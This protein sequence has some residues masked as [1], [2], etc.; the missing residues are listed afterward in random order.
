M[1]EHVEGSGTQFPSCPYYV[2]PATTVLPFA[3]NIKQTL[4]HGLV[5]SACASGSLTVCGPYD[6]YPGY[7]SWFA[8]NATGT[9]TFID[10]H[11]RTSMERIIGLQSTTTITAE[12]SVIG[13]EPSLSGY[14]L[15]PDNAILVDAYGNVSPDNNG[16][17]F[18]LDS[19]PYAGVNATAE[20]PYV[21]FARSTD[22]GLVAE[23]AS[24]R[25]GLFSSAAYSID[26]GN[27]IEIIHSD[28]D[29]SFSFVVGSFSWNQSTIY[30]GLTCPVGVPS[31]SWTPGTTDYA[32]PAGLTQVGFGYRSLIGYAAATYN[33]P[34]GPASSVC[35]AGILTLDLLLPGDGVRALVANATG[36]RVYAASNGYVSTNKLV[37]VLYWAAT[38]NGVVPSYWYYNQ[39][40]PIDDGQANPTYYGG[41]FSGFGL[42]FDGPVA[43]PVSG[44]Y[45]SSEEWATTL[46]WHTDLPSLTGFAIEVER[47]IFE[48]NSPIYQNDSLPTLTVFPLTGPGSFVPSAYCPADTSLLAMVPGAS[49]IYTN[50]LPQQ[51]LSIAYSLVP[52]NFYAGNEWLVCA[53]INL[54]LAATSS[55]GGTVSGP[56]AQF[57]QVVN[58]SGSRTF[59]NLATG[60]GVITSITGVISPLQLSFLHP[61]PDNLLSLTLPF[62]SPSG[63]GLQTSTVPSYST[64]AFGVSGFVLGVQQMNTS[65]SDNNGNSFLQMSNA[66]TELTSPDG[67]SSTSVYATIDSVTPSEQDCNAIV[68]TLQANALTDTATIDVPFSYSILV[69][70]DGSFERWAVCVTG[71]LKVLSTPFYV[72]PANP[73]AYI[74]HSGTGT[75]T[76]YNAW[77]QASTAN[78]VAV[79]SGLYFSDAGGNI[80]ANAGMTF[81]LGSSGAYTDANNYDI[82]NATVFTVATSNQTGVLT[83]TESLGHFTSNNNGRVFSAASILPGSTTT[84]P[85]CPLTAYPASPPNT[86]LYFSLSWTI[87]SVN[88]AICFQGNLTVATVP[89]SP[90]GSGSVDDV[91]GAVNSSLY[92]WYPVLAVSGSRVYTDLSIG[93]SYAQNITSLPTQF[94]VSSS[95]VVND[96]LLGVPIGSTLQSAT[97]AILSKCG[98]ALSFTSPPYYPSG[99]LSNPLTLALAESADGQPSVV[100]RDLQPDSSSF[101]LLSSSNSSAL[102]CPLHTNPNLPIPNGTVFYWKLNGT[103]EDAAA[104][105]MSGSLQIGTE[106]VP[107]GQGSTALPV[108][109]ISGTRYYWDSYTRRVQVAAI[110]GLVTVPGY[111]NALT[112]SSPYLQ[113]DALSLGL[114]FN[115]SIL[116]PFNPNDYPNSQN[117]S[118]FDYTVLT[119]SGTAVSELNQNQQLGANIEFQVSADPATAA[120]CSV[121][122]VQSSPANTSFVHVVYHF[123]EPT[124]TL[125][126]SL[127][128]E[129]DVSTY[130]GPPNNTGS[131]RVVGV[132]GNRTYS[133]AGLPNQLQPVLGLM[134]GTNRIYPFASPY[135]DSNGFNFETT[136][137]KCQPAQSSNIQLYSQPGPYGYWYSENYIFYQYLYFLTP[138]YYCPGCYDL[139]VTPYTP[140]QQLQSQCPTEGILDSDSNGNGESTLPSLGLVGSASYYFAYVLQGAPLSIQSSSPNWYGSWTVIVNGSVTLAAVPTVGPGGNEGYAI[141]NAS[142]TRIFIDGTGAITTQNII[143]VATG[144]NVVATY[145]YDQSSG[146]FIDGNGWLLLLNGSVTTPTG[147]A[148]SNVLYVQQ[149]FSQ[150]IS[151]AAVTVGLTT[152]GIIEAQQQGAYLGSYIDSVLL[153]P[154]TFANNSAAISSAVGGLTATLLSAAAVRQ[155]SAVLPSS[156]VSSSL[157]LSFQ[158]RLSQPSATSTSNASPFWQVCASGTLTV[159]TTRDV[160]IEGSVRYPVTA[161]SGTRSVT[162]YGATYFDII[163]GLVTGSDNTS[164][165]TATSAV[166]T[167]TGVVAVGMQGADNLLAFTPTTTDIFPV[168]VTINGLGLLLSSPAVYAGSSSWSSQVALSLSTNN[169]LGYNLATF[170][171]SEVYGPQAVGELIA[172]TSSTLSCPAAAVN[173]AVSLPLPL[174]Y[175]LVYSLTYNTTASMNTPAFACVVAEMTVSGLAV[176]TP[177]GPAYALLTVNGFHYATYSNGGQD[178]VPL[179][180]SVS[181]SYVQLLY[182]TAQSPAIVDGNGLTL[183]ALDLPGLT[184]SFFYSSATNQYVELGNGGA[185]LSSNV[186]LLPASQLSVV[187]VGQAA[188]SYSPAASVSSSSSAAASAASSSAPGSAVS[189]AAATAST[190]PTAPATSIAAA[191]SSSAVAAV[192]STAASSSAAAAQPV[193]SSTSASSGG[194]GV[195]VPSSSA[196]GAVASSSASVAAGV[197]SSSSSSSSSSSGV[198]SASVVVPPSSSSSSSSSGLSHGAIAGIVIGSVGGALLILLICL[199]LLLLSRRSGKNKQAER[200]V[201]QASD[202]SVVRP[203][204]MAGEPSQLAAV[205]RS[206]VRGG[207]GIEMQEV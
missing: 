205:D 195:V 22:D 41:A 114:S 81:T 134:Q 25:V 36:V 175:L 149:S 187:P 124:S 69:Q 29:S 64:G 63:L 37:S 180:A 67:S 148:Y 34:G 39:S 49:S 31:V 113:G 46:E 190:T 162:Q 185:L 151:P 174:T 179:N 15:W 65:V 80:F 153:Q 133:V 26:Y 131:Y 121:A 204:V 71:A 110:T 82:G 51:Q 163:A 90:L 91:G 83:I 99:V 105:C 58:A 192:T 1:Q 98:L 129:Y 16:L 84:L 147:P 42:L 54:T 178:S 161:A 127:I 76:F 172:S 167:I 116:Q 142:G 106:L 95:G 38:G 137:S 109:S 197:T 68:A 40:N 19:V 94:S 87:S 169:Q 186:Y 111:Y 191:S 45:G 55:P 56:I 3:Y 103:I 128:V 196:G 125:C 100:D 88:T 168:S 6:R 132:A 30:S 107:N 96:N 203:S 70:N 44:P 72:S 184:Y 9:R 8:V 136:C 123:R 160:A 28:D 85:V 201:P 154:L 74:I 52:S 122:V 47:F 93:Q 17:L 156:A 183:P 117:S 60:V 146:S 13:F 24:A 159:D 140:G 202:S 130:S 77:G 32:D 92:T 57:F 20:T 188:C 200:Q 97:T 126:G 181:A 23:V 150:P 206:A 79:N 112:L 115:T 152:E 50:T 35:I 164:M 145:L 143:G 43:P 66:L 176:D 33:T 18:M 48:G 4:S 155:L 89:V 182:L 157:Q 165:V 119:W 7:Q 62:I 141:V 173:G 102:Q 61:L 144:L 27:V 138:Q 2:P 14:P 78:I 108:T 170:A 199:V 166:Q 5:V 177:L 10:V 118:S 53:N 207:G 104:E 59:I 120:D 75:R 86:T 189:T 198:S 171:L 101:I 194:G 139:T 193:P 158:Y 11:N 135:V 21:L 73:S 12:Q